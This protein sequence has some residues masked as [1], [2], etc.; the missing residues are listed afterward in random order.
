MTDAIENVNADSAHKIKVVAKIKGAQ[1]EGEQWNA[2]F[3]LYNRTPPYTE[4]GR[5]LEDFDVKTENTIQISIPVP[6]DVNLQDDILSIAV[7]QVAHDF[8]VFRKID[9]VLQNNKIE[10]DLAEST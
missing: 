10:I 6:P 2:L 5:V 9:P 3:A 8:G 1:Y 7:E 4:V